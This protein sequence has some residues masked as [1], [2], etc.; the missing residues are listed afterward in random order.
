MWLKLFLSLTMFFVHYYEISASVVIYLLVTCTYFENI[1]FHI[2]ISNA[3][4]VIQNGLE[5]N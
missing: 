5:T 3:Y 4:G 1:V 2:L